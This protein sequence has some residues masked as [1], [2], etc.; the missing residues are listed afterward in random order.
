M[1]KSIFTPHYKIL[2]QAL[3]GM[4]REARLTQRDLA[5]KLKRPQNTVLRI[6]Q[7]ERRV[8]MVEFWR[9]CRACGASFEK[10]ALEFSREWKR[11]DT[12]RR[13]GKG[14]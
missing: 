9:I 5:R 4:R 11:L 7:G 3:V 8:D 13:R 6:E 14:G 2:R 10:L 12:A 1:E